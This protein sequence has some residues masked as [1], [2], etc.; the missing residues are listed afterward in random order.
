MRKNDR[1]FFKKLGVCPQCGKR[2]PAPGRGHCFE[3]L[4]TF[5]GYYYNHCEERTTYQKEH[6]DRRRELYWNKKE[7]GICV[8]C[9]KPATHGLYCY[10]CSVKVRRA[11][12]RRREKV[13]RERSDKSE[14]YNIRSYL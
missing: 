10:E 14:I 12:I 1:D 13:K 11:E 7:N 5:K 8:K 3:C 9:S 6:L 2:V 4:D